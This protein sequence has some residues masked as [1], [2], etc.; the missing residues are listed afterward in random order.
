MVLLDP[1]WSARAEVEA[2]ALRR[3]LRAVAIE[4]HHAGST[5]VAGLVAKPIVDVLVAAT[6]AARRIAAAEDSDVGRSGP[7]AR[8]TT[9]R[10]RRRRRRCRRSC[11]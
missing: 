3:A 10:P 11:P 8:E 4:I 2:A 5:A 6:G 7:M 9:C 1:S